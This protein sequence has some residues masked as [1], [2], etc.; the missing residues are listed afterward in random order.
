MDEKLPSLEK[1]GFV[2]ADFTTQSVVIKFYAWRPPELI[3]AIENL[4]P[5][6]VINLKTPDHFSGQ[7]LITDRQK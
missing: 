1:N 3:E 4:K 6:H 2:V 5:H 7:G